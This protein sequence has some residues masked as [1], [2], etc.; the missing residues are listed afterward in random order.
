MDA[1][2]RIR[3]GKRR[4]VMTR[5]V[6]VCVMC[7]VV[8]FFVGN[9]DAQCID[10]GPYFNLV[11]GNT[12]AYLDYDEDGA[13]GL[14]EDENFVYSVLDLGPW[15]KGATYFFPPT[16]EPT[17]VI[18]WVVGPD[19]HYHLADYDFSEAELEVSYPAAGP[20]DG[21]MEEGS[22]LEVDW[23]EFVNGAYNGQIHMKMS[24]E[25]AGFSYSTPAGDFDDCVLLVTDQYE[26]GSYMG[27][28]IWIMARE[29]GM[30]LGLTLR[31]R[32]SPPG[33][34][35]EDMEVLVEVY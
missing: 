5:F 7:S 4:E 6:V 25:A 22:Y 15:Y 28:Q 31:W 8:V 34:V 20:I 21:C 10:L 19:G 29:V 14:V 26:N 23:W 9:A 17:D 16:W 33:F 11:V 13:G 27:R 1:A 30:V 18:L 2:T 24:L 35:P 32:E 12:L 3:A